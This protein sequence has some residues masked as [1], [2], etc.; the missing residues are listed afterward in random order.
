MVFMSL[1]T[2]SALEPVIFEHLTLFHCFNCSAFTFLSL[3]PRLRLLPVWLKLALELGG[4]IRECRF[5]GDCKGM[6]SQNIPSARTFPY[7]MSASKD[8]LVQNI[9][10]AR[11][12]QY[13]IFR[14]QGHSSPHIQLVKVVQYKIFSRQGYSSKK[15]QVVK[16]FQHKTFNQQ[17][18]SSAKYSV[19]KIFQYLGQGEI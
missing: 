16:T 5:P 13:K 2:L 7:K 9:P 4:S 11:V 12:F 19:S 1:A 8:I 17:G 10:S 18:Q 6:A 14:Q 3:S 15:I